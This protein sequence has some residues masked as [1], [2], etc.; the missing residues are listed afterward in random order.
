[1]STNIKIASSETEWIQSAAKRILN[2]S[3]KAIR[4]QNYFS[5]VLSG[6][7]T[8][9]PVYR[10]LAAK[11]SDVE[12]AWDKWFIFW[13]DERCV[14]R[15]HSESNF[16]MSKQ[17]L[18]DHVPIPIE[19]IF[20]IQGQLAPALAARKYETSIINFF[21]RR[22]KRFDTVLLG[23]GHD[24]HIASLFPGAIS[25]QEKTH[26]V[27]STRHPQTNTDRI[28]L[29]IPALSSAK[30]IIFLVRGK[31]KSSVLADVIQNP[32]TPPFYPAKLIQSKETNLEWII[33]KDAAKYLSESGIQ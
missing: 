12:L 23:L 32:K 26:W 25:L 30:N 5:F 7:T 14:P 10:A 22:E 19:N 33:D 4:D 11:K 29:T 17:A 15:D 27:V 18:L 21:N 28:S 1:M 9:E 2:L 24:G 13:G 8:P 3:I 6:G 16:R 20:R 31:G